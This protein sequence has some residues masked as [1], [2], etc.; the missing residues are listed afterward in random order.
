MY[1]REPKISTVVFVGVVVIYFV[2]V[3]FGPP[4][5]YKGLWPCAVLG[6]AFLKPVWVREDQEAATTATSIWDFARF[7]RWVLVLAP[8]LFLLLSYVIDIE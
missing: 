3:A 2:V 1:L 8:L 5:P 7:I 6:V 4:S